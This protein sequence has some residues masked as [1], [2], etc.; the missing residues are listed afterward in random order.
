MLAITFSGWAQCRLATDPDPYDEPRGVSGYMRAYAG[1]PDLDRIIRFQAPPFRRSHTPQIG[2]T[3]RSVHV[4]GSESSA[5]PLNGA[6][7]DLL[8]GAKFEGR[9]GVIA[10]DGKEPIVPFHLALRRDANQVSRATVPTDPA[11]PFREFNASA[12]SGDPGLIERETGIASIFDLW[13]DRLA[14]LDRSVGGASP[15]DVPALGERI[16]FL[17]QAITNPDGVGRFF[18]FKM[19]WNYLLRSPVQETPGGLARLLPGFVPTRDPWVAK[20]WFGGWDADAQCFYVGGSLEIRDAGEPAAA[21]SMRRPER[22]SD[23]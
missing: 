18:A 2:V 3:V 5:H 1:E 23:I 9:N 11:A 7:L 10:E 15:E 8:D 16:D 4:H 12:V 6:A 20:F 19:E 14:V 22:L 17:R 13:R 21:R